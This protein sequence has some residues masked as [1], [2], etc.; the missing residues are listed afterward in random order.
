[1]S[2]IL[3]ILWVLIISKNSQGI[4]PVKLLSSF[5]VVVILLTLLLRLFIFIFHLKLKFY[6]KVLFNYLAR[7]I[8]FILQ[9]VSKLAC[10]LVLFS[11]F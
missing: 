11:F 10:A 8:L 5:I 7:L 1:M 2:E 6:F 9:L 4:V 3:K